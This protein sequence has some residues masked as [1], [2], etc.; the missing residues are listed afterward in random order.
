MQFTDAFTVTAD[1]DLYRSGE[2]NSVC[3]HASLTRSWQSQ[4]REIFSSR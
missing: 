2:V 1:L 4:G 3:C